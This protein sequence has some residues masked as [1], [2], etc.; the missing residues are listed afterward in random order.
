MSHFTVLVIGEEPELQLAPYH[1]F[2]CTGEV[3]EYVQ[4]IDKLDEAT[5]SFANSTTTRN[6]TC[7]G[8]S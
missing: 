5:E 7:L 3:D 2:E 8:P 6:L 1:E 4:S